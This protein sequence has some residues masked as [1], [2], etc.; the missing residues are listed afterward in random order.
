MWKCVMFHCR[1]CFFGLVLG[2]SL[3]LGSGVFKGAVAKFRQ[4]TGGQRGKWPWVGFKRKRA[5]RDLNS[6]GSAEEEGP[7]VSCALGPQVAWSRLH[8]MQEIV[9]R[10]GKEGGSIGGGKMETQPTQEHWP[11]CHMTFRRLYTFSATSAHSLCP[12]RS[13]SSHPFT[14]ATVQRWERKGG[15]S[16]V[17]PVS[18]FEPS[19]TRTWIICVSGNGT[20]VVKNQLNAA[21]GS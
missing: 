7:L 10:G 8:Q 19:V 4:Y 2:L 17:T 5:T 1:L 12:S 9:V 16:H 13:S 6:W 18:L 14:A 15:E 20:G 11:L 21:R 3:G